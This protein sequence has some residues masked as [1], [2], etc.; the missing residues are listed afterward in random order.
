MSMVDRFIDQL[1]Q[2]GL[3]VTAGEKPG[4][5]LLHGPRSE[6]T[7]DLKKALR[8]FKPQ[9]LERFGKAE[10][11]PGGD[12]EPPRDGDPDQESESCG[13]CSRI[14]TA[15]DRPRL[16]DPL[17]CDRGKGPRCPYKPRAA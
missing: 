14:V 12:A 11:V 17:F 1:R 2:R 3:S 4:E 15:K 9:L 6:V 5:L 13:V 8:A 7:D 16:A 10:F